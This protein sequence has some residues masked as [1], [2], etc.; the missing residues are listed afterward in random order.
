MVVSPVIRRALTAEQLDVALDHERAH[1]ASHDNLRRLILAFTPGLL[2]G[3]RSFSTLERHWSRLA[4][5]A[6]DDDAVRGDPNRAL[7]LA[8]ALVNV[9]RIGARTMPL[10]SSLLDGGDLSERVGRLLRPAAPP[11]DVRP[12]A[13]TAAGALTAMACI[14]ALALHPAT[15]HS[16]HE[17]LEHFI[18]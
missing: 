7:N 5:Y 13:I 6:A 15:L 16:A 10:T 14:V 17:A 8:A 11:S 2:P 3:M 18:R 12:L 1:C 9:A 4:E